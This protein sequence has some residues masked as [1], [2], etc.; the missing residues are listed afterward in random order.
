[1][2]AEDEKGVEEVFPDRRPP[3]RPPEEVP[4]EDAP[5]FLVPLAMV[6]GECGGDAGE[7]RCSEDLRSERRSLECY[8]RFRLW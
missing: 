8:S 3:V 7:R 2:Y 6:S 1:M 5:P 4:L